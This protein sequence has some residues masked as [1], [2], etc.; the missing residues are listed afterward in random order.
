MS[1]C[2]RT[3]KS[4]YNFCLSITV[5]CSFDRSTATQ[6]TCRH[7][8][9]QTFPN[10]I[11]PSFF[12]GCTLTMN[13][14]TKLSRCPATPQTQT[15]SRGRSRR[16]KGPSTATTAVAAAF[17]FMKFAMSFGILLWSSQTDGAKRPAHARNAPR[18]MTLWKSSRRSIRPCWTARRINLLKYRRKEKPKRKMTTTSSG[19]G[20]G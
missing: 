12:P 19:G 7:R 16:A 11:H 4:K 13:V 6:W 20:R 2:L 1:L 15:P 8:S 3:S 17:I 18:Q 5:S 9:N 14:T 10:S